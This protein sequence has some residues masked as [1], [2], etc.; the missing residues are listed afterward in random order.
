MYFIKYNFFINFFII[1]VIKERD[2]IL[3]KIKEEIYKI[4]NAKLYVKS[5]INNKKE[6]NLLQNKTDN[7][8]KKNYYILNNSLDE[9]E[10]N[11]IYIT[12]FLKLL[13]EYPELIYEIISNSDIGII[14]N[15][16][17]SF[18]I[19]NFYTDYLSGSFIENNL[20]YVIALLLK[21]EFEKAENLNN[22]E[23]Y[24]E[25]TK[26]GII[27]ITLGK[28]PEVQNFFKVIIINSIEKIE[29][30]NAMEEIEVDVDEISTKLTE[31][32]TVKKLDE[33]NSFLN[34]YKKVLNDK[35]KKKNIINMKRRNE[36]YKIFVEKY[37]IDIK[38]SFITEQKNEAKKNNKEELYIFLSKIEEEFKSSNN[39]DLYSNKILMENFLKTSSPSYLLSSYQN[40]FLKGIDL[41][42]QL[43]TDF[44]N[45]IILMPKII[46]SI[47]KI[48]SILI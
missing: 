24:L 2:I 20:L 17:S 41:I 40:E 36:N 19:N 23:N 9:F 28:I 45:N 29:R 10:N 7:K 3:D 34:V 38:L 25:N 43:I 35:M 12:S 22:L 26:L 4:W 21:N 33:K 18:L 37:L 15:N 32:K 48:I 1:I 31:T 13:W 30:Y 39:E 46:K 8:M 14:K 44:E 6:K 27:L 11:K 5:K 16:L 42:N 47:C